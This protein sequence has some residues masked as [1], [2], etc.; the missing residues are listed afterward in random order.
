[1]AA[2]VPTLL[3]SSRF[4][5]ALAKFDT[6]DIPGITVC[7]PSER[8]VGSSTQTAKGNMRLDI[9]TSKRQWRVETTHLPSTTVEAIYTYLK[10]QKLW[11][12][13]DWWCW[14]L[15]ASTNTVRARITEWRETP[16]ERAPQL[17]AMS[18]T[19]IEQ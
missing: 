15:G 11:G 14:R 2:P 5:P 6:Y 16:L 18:F 4:G 1:M 19:V 9:V 3:S 17:W 12:W 10:A 8:E 13:G 7:E